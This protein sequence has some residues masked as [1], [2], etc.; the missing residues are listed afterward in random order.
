MSEAR[1]VGEQAEQLGKLVAVCHSPDIGELVAEI[2]SEKISGEVFGLL[3]EIRPGPTIE[4]K[5]EK[6][7]C[8]RLLSRTGLKKT[9]WGLEIIRAE[10]NGHFTEREK[11]QW[12]WPFDEAFFGAVAADAFLEATIRLINL[13]KDLA[14]AALLP[15]RSSMGA[16]VHDGKAVADFR[17]RHEVLRRLQGALEPSPE[18]PGKDPNGKG[19]ATNKKSRKKEGKKSQNED[20]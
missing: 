18:P 6:G 2:K 4:E 10:K 12:V 5:T 20:I 19:A 13:E 14:A 16:R 8:Q 17:I 1:A 11:N 3:D 7:A 15:L 9:S